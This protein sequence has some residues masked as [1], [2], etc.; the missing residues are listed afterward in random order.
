[1]ARRNSNTDQD[2]CD[3]HI[4]PARSGTTALAGSAAVSDLITDIYGVPRLRHR[5]GNN[6]HSSWS[7]RNLERAWEGARIILRT[8]D[9]P[10][11]YTWYQ[12]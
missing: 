10:W 12:S 11:L 7:M 8:R 3:G 2:D 9:Q 1:M 6:L 5:E 4:L